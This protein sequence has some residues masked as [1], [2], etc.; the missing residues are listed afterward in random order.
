MVGD[1]VD[2]EF[3]GQFVTGADLV[4]GPFTDADVE[5]FALPDDVGK[6]LH[7]LFQRGFEVVPV[8]LVQVDV[9]GL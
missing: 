8:C 5:G 7:R 1:E 3:F 9:V 2:A 4:G 6:C